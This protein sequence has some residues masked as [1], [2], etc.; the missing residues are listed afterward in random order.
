ML[1][2]AARREGWYWYAAASTHPPAVGLAAAEPPCLR[3][4]ALARREGGRA[5]H[6]PAVRLAGWPLP[7]PFASF[8]EHAYA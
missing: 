8:D 5:T 4:S 2:N 6:P 3:R 1:L 7:S